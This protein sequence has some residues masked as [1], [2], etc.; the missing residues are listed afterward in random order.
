[1]GVTIKTKH[2]KDCDMGY[3]TFGRF[4]DDIA[5]FVP[6]NPNRGTIRFLEQCDCEGKLSYKECKELLSD[7][8][9]MP[10]NGKYYGYLGMGIHESLTIP[11][12][13][14]MLSAA[15]RYRCNLYWCQETKNDT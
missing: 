13:K 3:I 4:R 11:L 6:S 7:I 2:F 14:E 5:K 15:Y 1:M 8:N 10:D 12:F 9:D